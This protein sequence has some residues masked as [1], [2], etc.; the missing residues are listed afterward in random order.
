MSRSQHACGD[1]QPGSA[2]SQALPLDLSRFT[3]EI[4]QPFLGETSPSAPPPAV[5]ILHQ[6]CCCSGSGTVDPGQA[7]AVACTAAHSAARRQAAAPRRGGLQQRR[8]WDMVVVEA[9]QW[10]DP[11]AALARGAMWQSRESS[12]Q[13]RA[14]RRVK[15]QDGS[16]PPWHSPLQ[17]HSKLR[18]RRRG[19]SS[20]ARR[21]S[22]G[23]GQQQG[24]VFLPSLLPGSERHQLGLS[25]SGRQPRPQPFLSSLG[26]APAS[27]SP[28]ASTTF[29]PEGYF[30][31]E[32][33][34]FLPSS[35]LAQHPAPQ[36]RAV[37]AAPNL[38]DPLGQ[39][40]PVWLQ[41]PPST[42]LGSP[43]QAPVPHDTAKIPS[44]PRFSLGSTVSHPELLAKQPF[45][46]PKHQQLK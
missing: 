43:V 26:T 44:L 36:P 15:D 39:R 21:A 1:C 12:R 4:F 42:P 8:T 5:L 24:L 23:A 7:H 20:I 45:S 25:P 10:G 16:W 2:P 34:D 38:G 40:V 37:P 11:G 29:Q 41:G 31:R 28:G 3:T 22:G 35:T 30:Q 33:S 6:H 9:Q 14:A 46:C 27:T 13:G 19:S 18:R 32:V 17:P